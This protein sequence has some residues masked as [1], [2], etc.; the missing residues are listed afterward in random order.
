MAINVYWACLEDIWML[1]DPPESVSDIFYKKYNFNRSEPTS[2]I[3]YCPAFNDNLQN[4][5]ALKSI[6]DYNFNLILFEERINMIA[7]AGGNAG[8]MYAT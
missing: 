5:F 4:L 3:N 6:Y 1:A 7:F 8:L 2:L